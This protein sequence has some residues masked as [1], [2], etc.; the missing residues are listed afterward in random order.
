MEEKDRLGETL[1]DNEYSPELWALV[2]KRDLL[3]DSV[4]AFSA[5]AVEAFLNF[6]GVVRLG[7][8][9]YSTHFERL[10]PIPKLRQLLLVC[11]R[12]SIAERDPLVKT[13]HRVAKSRNSLVHPEAQ[14]LPGYVPAEAR[15]GVKIPEAA[16]EAVRDMELFFEQF[17]DAVPNAPH[18]VPSRA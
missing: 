14:E 5:M 3:S 18:L 10:G 4:R 13:L 8:E 12:L 1:R 2:R 16:R 11:D 9:E 15:G 17:V 7:E 6:Y